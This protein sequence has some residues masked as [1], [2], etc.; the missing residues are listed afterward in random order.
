MQMYRVVPQREF[1][2]LLVIVDC[3]V[4]PLQLV[5]L[6]TLMPHLAITCC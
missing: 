6:Q 2:V 5:I 3:D 1:A 4:L